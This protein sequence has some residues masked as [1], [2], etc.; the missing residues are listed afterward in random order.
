[1]NQFSLYPSFWIVTFNGARVHQIQQNPKQ[2]ILFQLSTVVPKGCGLKNRFI[3]FF[4]NLKKGISKEHNFGRQIAPQIHQL[5]HCIKQWQSKFPSKN[6]A[7]GDQN[8]KS[9]HYYFFFCLT[10]VFISWKYFDPEF[11]NCEFFCNPIFQHRWRI[12]HV[13]AKFLRSFGLFPF[14]IRK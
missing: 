11:K 7:Q 1:M 4:W 14:S 3:S 9:K 2:H 5:I 12:V 6:V 13:F 10:T 8:I